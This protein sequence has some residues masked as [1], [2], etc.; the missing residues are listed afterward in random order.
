MARGSRSTKRRTRTI[1]S[2]KENLKGSAKKFFWVIQFQICVKT[3]KDG[4]ADVFE[5]E[6]D[7]EENSGRG[8]D[9]GQGN[10]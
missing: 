10:K 6:D 3:K 4:D 7:D 5:D 9:P 1:T 8:G 2:R